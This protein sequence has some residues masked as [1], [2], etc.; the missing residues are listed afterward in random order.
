MNIFFIILLV[1]GFIK[2]SEFVCECII[3]IILQIKY[4]DDF[5]DIN[6]SSAL[7]FLK[8]IYLL[9]TVGLDILIITLLI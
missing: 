7:Y 9:P 5:E 2:L 1:L 3:S 8:D 6:R 4:G